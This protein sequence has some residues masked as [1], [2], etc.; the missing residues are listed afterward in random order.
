MI[1]PKK[2]PWRL[3]WTL[4]ALV[5]ALA[6]IGDGLVFAADVPIAREI[7]TL[8]P[9]EGVPEWKKQ[10]DLARDLVR[11]DQLRSAAEA[12][13]QLLLLKPH[14]EEAR[15]E[16]GKVLFALQDFAILQPIL[17][18]LIENDAERPEYLAMV[19][20]VALIKGEYRR[21]AA[22]LGQVYALRPEGEY[23][24]AILA[25]LVKA[26][27]GTGN[28]RIAFPLMEQLYLRRKNDQELLL[29]LARTAKSLGLESKA[30]TY[31]SR[32]V[33]QF[34][35]ADTVLLEAAALFTKPESAEEGRII[36]EKYLIIH[37]DYLP[38]HQRLAEYY[39]AKND[40]RQALPHLV[41][42]LD[43]SPETN[44]NLLLSAA[45]IY[46]EVEDR[47]DKA[48]QYFERYLSLHPDREDI[49]TEIRQ[50]RTKLVKNLLAIIENNGAEFL[51]DDLALLNI[52]RLAV[53][54][55]MAARL[56]RAGK[57]IELAGVLAILAEHDPDR[58]RYAM[59]LADL[60]LA[61]RNPQ[62]ALDGLAKVQ[63]GPSRNFTYWQKRAS[64]EEQLGMVDQAVTS[65]RQALQL[66][67][68]ENRLR[69]HALTLAGAYGM[70]A[71]LRQL[72]ASFSG[73]IGPGSVDLY[74]A[75]I[76]SLR[77]N[78]LFTTTTQL[79][80][81]L[82][83]EKSL[84]AADRRRVRLHQIGTLNEEGKIYEAEGQLRSLLALEGKNADLIA[85]LVDHALDVN[86][87]EG[88]KKW[89]KVLTETAGERPWKNHYEP[90]DQQI[91]LRYIH[92]QLVGKNSDAA[93][94]ELETYLKGLKEHLGEADQASLLPFYKLLAQTYLTKGNHARS[95]S[96]LK[97]YLDQTENDPE[98]AKLICYTEE[99]VGSGKD[100]CK[101]I[102]G[103]ITPDHFLTLLSLAETAAQI[104]KK[105]EAQTS[106]AES[107]NLRPDSLRASILQ[108][109]LAVRAGKADKALQIYAKL[110]AD[111]PKEAWFH[112]R[113][114]DML[115]TVGEYHQ[116]VSQLREED[117]QS[118]LTHKLL[119]ARAL[120]ATNSTTEALSQY[121]LLLAKPVRQEYLARIQRQIPAKASANTNG[122]ESMWQI[123]AFSGSEELAWLDKMIEPSLFVDII[124]LPESAVTAEYY[125]RFRWEKSIMNEYLA[126]KAILAKKFITAEKQHQKI[127]KEEQ[128]PV[129]LKDLAGIYKRL[130][131]YG[132]EAEVYSSLAKQG[133][134]SVELQE[135]IERNSMTR[136]P[137][138]AAVTDMISRNG[139]AGSIDLYQRSN[140]LDF[141]FMPHS[142][143]ELRLRFNELD[144]KPDLIE[145]PAIE[146]RQLQ[147]NSIMNL[148]NDTSLLTDFGFHVLDSAGDT[149]MIYLFGLE[150]N[151]D[152]IMKGYCHYEQDVVADSIASLEEG[153]S[154]HGFTAGL[155][156]EAPSG[157]TIGGEFRRMTYNDEN[158]QNR[159]YLWS[160]YSVF[161]EFNTYE[162]K[163]SY[164]LQNDELTNTLSIDP[165]SGDSTASLSYWSPGNYW[166]HNLNL[167]FQQL[168]TGFPMFEKAP[169]YYAV[170]LA[171]GYESGDNL[172][173]SGKLDIFLEMSNHFLLNGNLQYMQSEDYDERGFSLS[174]VYRW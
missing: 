118:D 45:R 145:S 79:Y 173:Y 55:L 125:H 9:S 120:W 168:L 4:V 171:V 123:F 26:L 60:Y 33:Q 20:R 129:A 144:Y 137:R 169:S 50:E 161:S 102:A 67:P 69:S 27:L 19:G 40:H 61:M 106:I 34:S 82:L 143:S 139:R 87:L 159:M 155:K 115:L 164:E 163:Y 36:W 38:F 29:L 98:L 76:T 22:N 32:L 153:V 119:L 131:D 157:F 103:Q 136:A 80:A 56:A 7:R 66:Q 162:L 13:R 110:A 92:L 64:L 132:K 75:M 149:T 91:F 100:V 23:G 94:K 12:Y 141:W 165:I 68:G 16:Y 124:N 85:A 42:I 3:L 24:T 158:A 10:W 105:T 117:N 166:L 41:I 172:I 126:R 46:S 112:E 116:I 35:L 54:R 107:V 88:A 174:L 104:G 160:A 108:A 83:K 147:A 25:D 96:L 73:K 130:G 93:V 101:G 167:H 138:L 99:A 37:P 47:P 11:R 44:E 43:E 109:R 89:L 77:Q 18:S 140:G 57:G 48:L 148:T 21:A 74:L 95:L 14:I 114:L 111:Q 170:D 135:S 122:G 59:Q 17:E 70:A 63:P 151:L 133:Q 81:T 150:H 78:G 156:L 154:R 65:Y 128:S 1:V 39:L 90:A 30:R 84:S 28:N 142:A 6:F 49:A 71:E 146:G 86:D 113:Y 72:V 134:Q 5:S 58:D 15:W 31:Y 53:Y 121:E 52:D 152:E 8:N 97:P 51:W 2:K 127:V 62:Q